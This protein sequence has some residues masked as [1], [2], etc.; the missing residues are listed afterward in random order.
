[1][2]P[3]QVKLTWIAGALLASEDADGAASLPIAIRER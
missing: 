2:V 1:M 3:M